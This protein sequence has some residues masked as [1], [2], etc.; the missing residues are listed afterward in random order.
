[1]PVIATVEL[2]AE[3]FIIGRLLVDIDDYSV[4]LTHFVPVGDQFIPYFW[5]ES[6]AISGI[7]QTLSDHDS[8]AAVTKSDQRAG[9]TL[10][11]IEWKQPM[12]KFLLVLMETDVLVS[13]AR[14]T[15][16]RWEFELLVSD[17]TDLA[18]F[19]SACNDR[20]ITLE[21]GRILQSGPSST[22][23]VGLTDK[24]HEILQL[25]FTRGYFE[26]P[27]EITVTELAGDLDISPQAAS[28][29][30]R[31]GLLNVVGFVLN[32]S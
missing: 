18:T 30:L 2:P 7:E 11:H 25:A 10:C 19:Q 12:D 24:Q 1:M 15:P 23:R 8:I 16:D 5:I 21:F 13:E 9:R 29:R 17:R 22:E 20:D 26:I 3:E 6:D 14:G 31:R 27:R 32:V 4:K 28:K